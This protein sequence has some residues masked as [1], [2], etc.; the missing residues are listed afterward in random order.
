MESEYTSDVSRVTRTAEYKKENVIMN[1]IVAQIVRGARQG[2][3]RGAYYVDAEALRQ[4]RQGVP[5][6]EYHV[7]ADALRQ[8]RQGVPSGEYHRG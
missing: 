4:A 6:G 8:A 7:D 3:P 5:S 2:V 1:Y